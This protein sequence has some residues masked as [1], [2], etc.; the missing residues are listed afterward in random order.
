MCVKLEGWF[1]YRITYLVVLLIVM[2]VY[3]VF[4]VLYVILGLGDLFLVQ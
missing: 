2:S 4:R 3:F 1:L